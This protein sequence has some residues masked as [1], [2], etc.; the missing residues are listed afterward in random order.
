[1]LSDSNKRA[2][3]DQ[4]GE[5]GL[6]GGRPTPGAGSPGGHS[7]FPSGNTFTFTSGPGG[8]G[9]SGGFAPT[10]P[11]KVFEYVSLT[12]FLIALTPSHFQAILW[13]LVL[14]GWWRTRPLNVR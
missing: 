3:Y 11:Q 2:V 9:S 4:F 8:F 7:S 12:A 14:L 1:V 13:V 5:E 6:K 10:D